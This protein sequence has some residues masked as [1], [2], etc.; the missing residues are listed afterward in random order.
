MGERD[1]AQHQVERSRERMSAIAQEV[2]R[3][4]TPG[5]AKERAKE[6]ARHRAYEARDKA[7][8]SPWLM[9]LVGAGL[10]ALIGR[11]VLTRAQDRRDRDWHREEWERPVR[12]GV[13]ERYGTGRYGM[14]QPQGAHG[15][16]AE[17]DEDLALSTQ[18]VGAGEGS[19]G[20]KERLSER[21][22]AVGD[23]AAEMKDR[24]GGKAEELSGRMS[25][26]AHEL[27]D[28]VRGQASALRER[29][30]DRD[31]V[32]TSAYESPGLWALGAAAVGALFGFALPLSDAE[33]E[34][35]EP[36][37]QKMREATQHAMD[38]A[39]AKMEERSDGGGMSSE[40]G[41]PSSGMGTTTGSGPLIVPPG[42]DPI[43]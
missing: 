29:I 25:D 5:Y 27:G 12:Y 7:V 28:R 42:P 19:P 8:D 31:A 22:S 2:S 40:P 9:P 10:G 15:A 34:V 32:R 21:A 11:A 23:R 13:Y 43:H 3:R 16:S 41:R 24:L 38:T 14:G 39:A 36:A 35:L 4:M 20:V 1:D 6:M 18:E 17:W 26:K 30:P 33:R 37:K